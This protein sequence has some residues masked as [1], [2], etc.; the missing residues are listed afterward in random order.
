[1]QRT[2]NPPMI[3]CGIVD[4]LWYGCTKRLRILQS[5]DKPVKQ[6]SFTHNLVYIS[7]YLLTGYGRLVTQ[8]VT[9]L[10]SLLTVITC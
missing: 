9:H 6:S 3:Y 10:R 5:A 4:R 2:S 1:M 8:C 7:F